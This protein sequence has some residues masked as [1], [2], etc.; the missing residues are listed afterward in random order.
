MDPIL[1]RG[2]SLGAGWRAERDGAAGTVYHAAAGALPIASGIPIV[3]AV[4]DLAPWAMPAAYQ[5]GVAARFGQRIRARLLRDA[6]AV[7]V[8]SRATGIEAR[9]LLH[10]KQ[11]RVRVVPLAARP[12]FRPS[13]AAGSASEAERLGLGSRYAVYAGRYDAR[14]DLPT[15][16]DA[17]GRLAA[18]PAPGGAESSVPWPPRICLVGASPDDRAALSRAAARA[19]VADAMAYAPQLPSARLA[20][21]VAGARFLVQPVRSEATGLAALEALAAG[22][23]VIASAVGALPET[24]GAAGIL[25]EPGDA[26]RLATALRAAWLDDDLH[27][28]LVAATLELAATRRTWADVAHDTRV[29]WA[30]VAKAAPLL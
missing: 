22:V 10:V 15:L 27:A 28:Q 24:V 9:R 6:A 30:A 8:P 26:A 3:A 18:E 12:E 16:L 14:Q 17:L 5:R 1:L 2:A 19:G 25:V 21:L 29:A 20:A 23:P 7:L 13:A 11:A 4:L